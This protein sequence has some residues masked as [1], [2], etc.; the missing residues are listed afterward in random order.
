MQKLSTWA[1]KLKHCR[2]IVHM[3]VDAMTPSCIMQF[4]RVLRGTGAFA[5]NHQGAF[6]HEK[7]VLRSLGL[8]I[9]QCIIQLHK[10][11]HRHVI[12]QYSVSVAIQT[13]NFIRPYC[14]PLRV[15]PFGEVQVLDSF[16]YKS[17]PWEIAKEGSQAE[18]TG[19]N[20]QP[21]TKEIRGT[22]LERSAKQASLPFVAL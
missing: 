2:N 20:T 21:Q 9:Q 10:S 17:G 22:T 18:T 6:A 3:V 11:A 12:C 8:S 14:W 4:Q 16:R 7:L 1:K 15:P 13:M 5:N 19:F